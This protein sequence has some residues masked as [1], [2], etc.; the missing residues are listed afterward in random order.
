MEILCLQRPG[1]LAQEAAAAGID[2]IALHS[3]RGYDLKAVWLLAGHLRRFRPDV[4]NVH[5]R[6]SLPYVALANGIGGRRPVVFSA[7]GLLTQDEQPK[8]RD[9]WAAKRLSQITAVS[10]PAGREYARLLGWKA[11]K[12]SES[13]TA[14]RR[15][16]RNEELRR[17]FRR[18]LGLNDDAFVF[19]RRGKREA[20]E[21]F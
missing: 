14:F 18:S 1:S 20:R 3:L 10:Q 5:D 6:S 4:I 12:S 19:R 9:R 17:Q 2:V 13:T 8:R 7:H 11:Q 16:D 15:S 21:R